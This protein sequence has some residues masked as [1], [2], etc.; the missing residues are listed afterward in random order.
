MPLPNWKRCWDNLPALKASNASV[1]KDKATASGRKSS[2]TTHPGFSNSVAWCDCNGPVISMVRV[3]TTSGANVGACL[4]KQAMLG[5]KDIRGACPQSFNGTKTY[6]APVASFTGFSRELLFFAIWTCLPIPPLFQLLHLGC[7][8]PS[9]AAKTLRATREGIPG[10]W[11]TSE[12]I[13]VEA[14]I[15]NPSWCQN[16]F[17]TV[18]CCLRLGKKKAAV[19]WGFNTTHTV[20]FAR[21][22][23]PMTTCNHLAGSNFGIL[24]FE[25]NWNQSIN[26]SINLN[27][28]NL[29]INWNQLNCFG[30]S[31]MACWSSLIR[32]Q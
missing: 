1:L 9:I 11:K 4:R 7:A 31:S 13:R 25:I 12:I 3:A 16:F 14:I 21:T 30:S 6:C 32:K 23:F 22:M 18:S 15:P 28:S 8:R 17:S 29:E 10:D 27:Q 2:I 24:K 19:R 5:L 26:Q 20:M